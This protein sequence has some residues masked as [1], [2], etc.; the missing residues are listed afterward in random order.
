MRERRT[1]SFDINRNSGSSSSASTTFIWLPLWSSRITFN[2]F[3]FVIFRPGSRSHFSRYSE[4]NGLRLASNFFP[5]VDCRH[6]L[7]LTRCEIQRYL[8]FFRNISFHFGFFVRPYTRKPT[9]DDECFDI[10]TCVLEKRDRKTKNVSIKIITWANSFQLDFSLFAA[11]F[12][13]NFQWNFI[14]PLFSCYTCKTF[15]LFLS[16]NIYWKSYIFLLRLHNIVQFKE[17]MTSNAKKKRNTDTNNLNTNIFGQINIQKWNVEAKL[18]VFVE[19]E[20][21][22]PM[23]WCQKSDRRCVRIV[24]N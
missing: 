11:W 2:D 14:L 8:R 13:T 22:M 9:N 4:K 5:F 15:S 17:R 1:S 19:I 7:L 24:C 12:R 16:V 3:H 18:N 6:R 23:K 20:V 10:T 21:S